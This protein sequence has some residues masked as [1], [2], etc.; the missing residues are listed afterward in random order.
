[1]L[2]YKTHKERRNEK[3]RKTTRN[4]PPAGLTS[5]KDCLNCITKLNCNTLLIK[6][7]LFEHSCLNAI[8]LL[9]VLDTMIYTEEKILEGTTSGTY[10]NK[11]KTKQNYLKKFLPML[12]NVH[13]AYKDFD[14]QK[15][16]DANKD[17]INEYLTDTLAKLGLTETYQNLYEE[18]T[19]ATN[20]YKL[21]QR[22]SERKEKE[23]LKKLGEN[24]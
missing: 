19:K 7:A 22:N 23:F 24:L 18:P 13:N 21:T 5:A 9:C 20:L 2:K 4:L 3:M 6:S 15:L 8:E 10:L 11:T 14:E 16:S 1:M 12:H 17:F